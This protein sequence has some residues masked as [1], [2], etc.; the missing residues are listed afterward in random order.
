[1]RLGS[2][3]IHNSL[4]TAATAAAIC[5]LLGPVFP[6]PSNLHSVAAFR[7]T[8]QSIK[9]KIDEAFINGKTTHGPVNPND[10]YSIQIFSTESEQMLFDYHHRGSDLLSSRPVDGDSVYR[11]GSVSKLITVYLLLLQAGNEI[12]GE[13]VTKYLPELAG[14]AYWDEITVGSLAG[15]LSDTTAESKSP[16]D[17]RH[18]GINRSSK[19]FLLNSRFWCFVSWRISHT[20]SR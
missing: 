12:F 11:I 13:K 16:Q 8:L 20:G 2:L 6:A 4:A 14:A 9:A 15:F 7:D 5:P 1:M 10:T 18:T 17:L 3:L 19:R